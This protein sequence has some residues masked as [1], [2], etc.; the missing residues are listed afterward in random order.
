MINLS[1]EGFAHCEL[2][3]EKTCSLKKQCITLN[4]ILP[5]LDKTVNISEEFFT[6]R[7]LIPCM[8]CEKSL[9]Q[10]SE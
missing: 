9:A 7:S 5:C 10:E 8:H 1:K 2:Y 6:T 3:V 4:R